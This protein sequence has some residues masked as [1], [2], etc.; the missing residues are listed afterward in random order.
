MGVYCIAFN[1][2]ISIFYSLWNFFPLHINTSR[3]WLQICNTFE[4]IYLYEELLEAYAYLFF[5]AK[6]NVSTPG[7]ETTMCC[8]WRSMVARYPTGPRQGS[9]TSAIRCWQTARFWRSMYRPCTP[10]S[11]RTFARF[12]D[13]SARGRN[14]NQFYHVMF[15]NR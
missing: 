1:K 10:S 4:N 13:I 15:I 8:I 7:P 6:F 5:L 9:V 14:S 3:N 11:N 12:V 2:Y